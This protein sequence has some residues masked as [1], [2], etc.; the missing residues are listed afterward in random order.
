MNQHFPYMINDIINPTEK[1]IL[2]EY[3]YTNDDKT[4]QRP[5]V[6]SKHPNW[7]ETDWPKDIIDSCLNKIFS[8]GFVVEDLSF[9]EDKIGLK[10]HTDYGSTPGTVG[11]T[12]LILL[13]ADPVAHTVFFDNWW[14][15]SDPL[16][17]FFTKQPWSPYY[18]KLENIHGELV[19][20][21]DLRDFLEVCR[22]QPE[23]I[24]DFVVDE[25][26][27]LNIQRLIHIRS[28]PVLDQNQKDQ[29]TGYTQPAPRKSDYSILTKYDETKKFDEQFHREY[30][31]DIKIE[32]LHGLTV[33]SVLTWKLN[34]AIVFNREQ[35]HA[36][37]SCHKKKTFITIFCHSK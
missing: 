2:L 21:N 14:P 17:A 33:E 23:T 4:D 13:D 3:F 7:N 28:L 9:R 8:K 30:L 27:I 32:D 18:Y 34:S 11:K 10:P 12:I 6:R 5:D 31:Y 1:Q 37:S 36:S 29:T 25:N 20:I 22:H 16:G 15:D 19:E 26:F 35:L 24:R